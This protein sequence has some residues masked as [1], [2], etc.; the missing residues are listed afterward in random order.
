[1]IRKSG[2]FSP[3]SFIKIDIANHFS[4]ADSEHDQDDNASATPVD[5]H[6][7]D[8]TNDATS[9]EHSGADAEISNT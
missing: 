9:D 3:V 8:E 1:V 7:N 6:E 4:A 5:D 2:P